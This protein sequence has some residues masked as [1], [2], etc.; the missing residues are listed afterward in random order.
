MARRYS[1]KK[2]KSGS[3]KPLKKSKITWLRY[4][5]KEIEQLIIKLSK[6]GKSQS[7]IGMILRDTYGV[8]DVRRILQTKMGKILERN[9][10]NKEIPEDLLNLI[11]KE[12]TLMKHSETNKKDM[13][14]KRGLLLTGSKI[15]RLVKYYKKENKLDKNWVYNRDKAK[16]L[17][18]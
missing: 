8:P 2:G 6:Q 14:A 13:S 10:L 16:L 15:N 5:E 11:K 1:G 18:S 17:I 12:I 9:K 3:K 4:D 7:E